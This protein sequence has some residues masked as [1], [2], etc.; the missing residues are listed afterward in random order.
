VPARYLLQRHPL[1]MSCRFDH[2]LVIT[3]AL[4][5]PVLQPLRPA[6]RPAWLTVCAAGTIVW[7]YLTAVWTW[8]LIAQH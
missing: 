2:C 4:P 1:P 3:W 5:A 6:F 7:I 8:T